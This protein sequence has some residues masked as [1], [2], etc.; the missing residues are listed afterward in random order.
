MDQ[1]YIIYLNMNDPDLL[2]YILPEYEAYLQD[3]QSTYKNAVKSYFTETKFLESNS[4]SWELNDTPG[5]EW[6][7]LYQIGLGVAVNPDNPLTEF[8]YLTILT[9]ANEG[10]LAMTELQNQLKSD[11]CLKSEYNYKKT[12][13]ENDLI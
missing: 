2:E 6:K 9:A 8:E 3:I 7:Q 12:E 1:P 10:Y 5:P 4:K 13:Y 11:G